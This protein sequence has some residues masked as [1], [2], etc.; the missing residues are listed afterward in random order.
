MTFDPNLAARAIADA[1]LARASFENLGGDLEPP[2]IDDAYAVQ[3]A[4]R[5]IWSPR[6][7][8]IVGLKIATTTKVMQQ[9]M[10]IDHPCG[11]M[12]YEKTLHQS[13]VALPISDFV[14]LR[15]ECELAVRLGT[16]LMARSNG[17]AHDRDSVRG[18]VGTVMAAFELIED[19]GADYNTTSAK[20][21][22]ADNA[23]NGGVVLGREIA[24][25]VERNL[26]GQSGSALHNDKPIGDGLTDDPM[27]ALAWCAN[28][29]I[30]RGIPL[31][32]GQI[33]ITGSLIPTFSAAAGDTVYFEIDN[34]SD[35]A[36]SVTA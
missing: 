14:N 7:G 15:I 12:I 13:G 11:G 24:V 30:S 34:I 20:T 28:L 36:L 29:A 22:I 33:V 4:L 8:E 6:K 17:A 3:D 23:W 25:P 26:N 19:R 31:R 18:A 1:H 2:T 10:G 27:G 32:A 5:P 9:L 16:D 21:L 35:V